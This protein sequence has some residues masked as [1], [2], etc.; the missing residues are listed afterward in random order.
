MTASPHATTVRMRIKR[1]AGN[2]INP[3]S[4]ATKFVILNLGKN[5]E[6]L[7]ITGYCNVRLLTCKYI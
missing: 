1:N 5:T 3:L 4:F 6:N 2:A 7:T